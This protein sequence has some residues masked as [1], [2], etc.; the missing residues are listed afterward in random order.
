M[1]ALAAVGE[2]LT[3]PADLGVTLVAMGDAL[4]LLATDPEAGAVELDV[5]SDGL[6]RIAAQLEHENIPE[7]SWSQPLVAGRHAVA[8]L[9]TFPTFTRRI[10][11]GVA[12]PSSS[13]GPLRAPAAVDRREREWCQDGRRPQH[14]LAGQVPPPDGS[15]PGAPLPPGVT[16]LPAGHP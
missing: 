14:V 4:N 7:Q 6:T 2:H 13:R 1:D 11:D 15:P 12:R 5:I 10:A 9:A 3:S 16:D 8:Q